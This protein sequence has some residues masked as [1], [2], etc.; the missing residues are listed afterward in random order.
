MGK[1]LRE[2]VLENQ[3]VRI[4]PRRVGTVMSADGHQSGYVADPQEVFWRGADRARLDDAT[5]MRVQTSAGVLLAEGS[6]NTL[7]SPR[8]V[9]GGIEVDLG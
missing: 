5:D 8:T 1:P 6:I 7:R 9:A 4:T 3:S 2:T